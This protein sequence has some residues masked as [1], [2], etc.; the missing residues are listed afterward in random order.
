MSQLDVFFGA[1]L[2]IEL[3]YAKFGNGILV[4]AFSAPLNNFGVPNTLHISPLK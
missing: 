1:E 3:K 4:F 2:M